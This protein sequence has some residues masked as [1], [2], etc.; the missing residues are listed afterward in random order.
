MSGVGADSRIDTGLSSANT[1][2]ERKADSKTQDGIRYLP[3]RGHVTDRPNILLIM[4]DQHRLSA[5]GAYADSPL[6]GNSPCRTPNIDR[7]AAEGIRFDTVYTTNPVCSPARGSVITGR[8]PHTHGICSNAH[9]LG[10]STHELPDSPDLL[11]RQLANLGYVSGY[12][13][14]WHLGNGQS[15]AFGVDIDPAKP[16][17]RGFIGQDFTGHGGGG[18]N[19]A[20]YRDWLG[21][22]GLSHEVRDW[23]ESAKQILPTGTLAGPAESTVPWFLADHTCSLIDHFSAADKPWFIWHN[24]WGPHGPYYAPA[25]YLDRYRDVDIPPWPNYDW[26]SRTTPGPHHVKIHPEHESLDWNDWATAIRHYYAF[27]TLI[28]EQI[29]RI[30]A[31][32]ESTGELDNTIIIF[33][34]DHG[35][36]AGSHGGLTDKGWQHFEEIQR[37]PM[38]I[39]LPDGRSAGETREG[40]VSLAD[41]YPTILSMAGSPTLPENLH[42]RSVLPL[43]DDSSTRWRNHVVVEFSGVNNLSATLRTLI[44]DGYKFGYSAGWPDQLYD[45]NSDPHETANLAELGEYRERLNDMRRALSAW[46]RE[47]NDPVRGIYDQGM[48]YHLE[49]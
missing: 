10:T 14:K 23:D 9:N 47:Y 44:K 15:K 2:E 35:E 8:Y 4:T 7:L 5:V 34:S 20:E 46:M 25:E 18:F 42:G 41:V 49:R 38:I 27:T 13:G 17:S 21:E 26:P 6:N 43:I 45:L 22:K 33:T 31:H 19:Y 29:G 3:G 30:Y 28:D 12:T 48:R 36:T 32:L 16:S 1:G 39:R 37:I 11:P 40:L 24:F